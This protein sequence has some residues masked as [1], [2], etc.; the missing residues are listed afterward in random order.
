MVRTIHA[1]GSVTFALLGAL[2]VGACAKH[3]AAPTLAATDAGR[4]D[5]AIHVKILGIN[6]F[7]GQ[8]SP[9]RVQGRPVGGA[10]ALASYLRAASAGMADRAFFVHAGDLVGASPA[11]SALLQ[12]EPS[13]MFLNLLAN[14]S[15]DTRRARN[16]A[17]NVIGTVGNHEFDEGLTELRRLLEGGRHADGPYLEDPWQG[18]RFPTVSANVLYAAT[19]Q[20]VFPPYVVR[21]VGGAKLAFVGAVLRRTPTIVMASAVA[22]LA[23]EDEADAVNRVI[24][25]LHAQGVHAIVLLIHQG[26]SQEPYTGLTRPDA[27]APTGA[28]LDVIR[29]LD[30]DVDVIISGHTHQFTNSLVPNAHGKPMLVVQAWSYATAFDDIDVW[31]DPVSQ[32][33]VA[34]RAQIIT[35]WNDEGPGRSPDAAVAALVARADARVAP[36]VEQVL[37]QAEAPI[38]RTTNAAGESVLGDLIADAQRDIAGADFAMINPGGIRADLPAGTITWGAAFAVQP[39]GNDVLTLTL[40]GQDLVDVLNEQWGHG[41][42]SGGR[43]L[44]ISG[45]M[46][47]WNGSTPEGGS[48]VI[49]VHDLHGIPLVPSRSYTLAT[50]QFLAEGGDGFSV[51]QRLKRSE[52]GHLDRDAL[53]EYLKKASRPLTVPTIPRIV[54][55]RRP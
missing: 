28:L 24:P 18:A 10:A 1:P 29:R 45:F 9:K 21:E 16:S 52:T 5:P 47:S 22:G 3:A 49:E 39:F 25:E 2:L 13:V 4:T 15:C 17:C 8:L 7:H 19:R 12:D 23:F 26:L 30:D 40:T 54:L 43:V 35:A 50:N 32:D 20:P 36:R 55:V 41:Q 11:N 6:D 53:V 14:S 37:A 51:L 38:E 27:T 42:P 44:S 34:K 48:R 33:I 46:Y 31:V